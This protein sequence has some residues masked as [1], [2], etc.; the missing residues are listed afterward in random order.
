VIVYVTPDEGPAVAGLAASEVFVWPR[1]EDRL[2][3]AFMTGA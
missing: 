2:K 1:D 3:M